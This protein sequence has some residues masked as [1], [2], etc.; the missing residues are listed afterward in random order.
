MLKHNE[1]RLKK[2]IIE[3]VTYKHHQKVCYFRLTY[4]SNIMFL[5]HNLLACRTEKAVCS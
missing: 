1:T 4:V 5:I 2:V 3:A